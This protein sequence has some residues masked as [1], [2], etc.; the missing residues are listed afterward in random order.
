MSNIQ[1]LASRQDVVKE[2]LAWISTPYV[3][4]QCL[5]GV[6]ADC[7]TLLLGIY[8][9]CGI[10]TES[11]IAIYADDW[12]FNTKNERYLLAVARHAS[13]IAEAVCSVTLAIEPGDIVLTRAA[14]SHIYNHGGIVIAW[15]RIVH[16][17]PPAVVETDATK[18]PLWTMKQIVAFDPWVKEEPA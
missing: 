11:D 18:D 6:A 1:Q 8:R 4:G 17:L 5:K 13:K 14:R 3:R 15:P 12:F 9:A 7:A 10:F 2:A 16:C